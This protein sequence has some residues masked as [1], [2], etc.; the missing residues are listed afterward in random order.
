MP[1]SSKK[2]LRH[3]KS[4]Y[5][6]GL[7]DKNAAYL[8]R[9]KVKFTYEIL[10]IQYTEPA[11]NHTYTPDFVITTLSGKSIIV[12]T[13][14]IWTYKDRLKHLLVRQQHPELDIRFVFTRS[15][16][17][18]SKSSKTTYADICN[19]LGR[20]KFKGVKWMYADKLTPLT[21]LEE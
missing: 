7:E 20:G 18:I 14:G 19:G 17:K 21:W 1:R 3:N 15:R 4:T 10:K 12:E 13:K 16:S 11:S 9:E 8:K 5:R 6:S 2:Y